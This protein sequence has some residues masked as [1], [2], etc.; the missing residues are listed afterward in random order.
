MGKK[1]HFIHDPEYYIYPVCGS[2]SSSLTTSDRKKV[3]CRKCMDILNNVR[4]SATTLAFGIGT[5][6]IDTKF[7]KMNASARRKY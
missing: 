4:K 1:T 6:T 3:T 5:Q 2:V 7:K